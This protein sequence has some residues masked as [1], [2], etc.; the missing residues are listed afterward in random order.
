MRSS[1]KFCR[2]KTCPAPV[3]TDDDPESIE[4][5]G[6]DHAMRLAIIIAF[7][8]VGSC[9]T[10]VVAQESAL[11]GRKTNLDLPSGGV[12]QYEGEEAL[13]ERWDLFGEEFEGDGVFF[14]CNKS[15]SMTGSKFKILQLAVTQCIAQFS[16]RVQFSVVFFDTHVLKFPASESPA[17]ATSKMKA[18]AI[19]TVMS[20]SPGGGA[21]SKPALIASLNHANASSAACKLILYF[22]DGFQTCP[23]YD[24]QVYGQ[25]TLDLVRARNTQRVPIHAIVFHSETACSGANNEANNE[26]WMERL[27]IENGGAFHHFHYHIVE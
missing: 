12:L 24:A 15:G 21:C 10:S 22:S 16:E 25:E 20:T 4:T 9:A 11:S 5:L 6:E 7:F 8:V 3:L 19:N 18:A 26:E 14:C 13:P 27:A 2:K 17:E 1:R 23:G